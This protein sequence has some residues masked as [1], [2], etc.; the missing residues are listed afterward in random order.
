MLAIMQSVPVLL[1]MRCDAWVAAAACLQEVRVKVVTAGDFCYVRMLDTD[2]GE[3]LH[4]SVQL[5]IVMQYF[6]WSCDAGAVAF[7]AGI[8]ASNAAG[9]CPSVTD[10][11]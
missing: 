5:Q 1:S 10:W 2:N 4:N 8:P 3:K 7:V 11:F 6:S 9:A